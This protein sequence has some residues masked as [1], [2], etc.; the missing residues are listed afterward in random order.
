[1]KITKLTAAQQRL[2]LS[3]GAKSASGSSVEIDDNY[4]DG[5]ALDLT[6]SAESGA[7]GLFRKLTAAGWA[8]FPE[9]P[10]ADVADP[11][12]KVEAGESNVIDATDRFTEE[13]F[14]ASPFQAE[15]E[16]NCPEKRPILFQ[17][18][19][20]RACRFASIESAAEWAVKA[21]KAG[22]TTAVTILDGRTGAG[23]VLEAI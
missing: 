13:G 10:E 12:E 9:A 1:M 5:F 3:L 19:T 14:T 17:K 18:D 20:G 23:V 7:E 11:A 2:A 22:D 4:V 6:K 21:I 15:P 8:G 16:E